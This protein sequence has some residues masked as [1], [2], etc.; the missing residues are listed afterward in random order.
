MECGCAH[1]PACVGLYIL[2]ILFSLSLSLC[3]RVCV[4]F[5][6]IIY[7]MLAV[8]VF[9]TMKVL[10]CLNSVS[11]PPTVVSYNESFF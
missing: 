7:T 9:L 2:I 1:A 5:G 10:F 11:M 4:R 8:I 3:V 6:K